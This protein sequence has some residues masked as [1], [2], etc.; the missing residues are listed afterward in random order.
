MSCIVGYVIPYIPYAFFIWLEGFYVYIRIANSSK[1]QQ[2]RSSRDKKLENTA[3]QIYNPNEIDIPQ[4]M[5]LVARSEIYLIKNSQY[6]RDKK[7]T[8]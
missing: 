7:S 8:N 5:E 1:L 2:T 4:L 3:H 6:W